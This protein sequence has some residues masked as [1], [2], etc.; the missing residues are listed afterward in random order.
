[1]RTFAGAG[2]S[3]L[4]R[5]GWQ[6]ERQR[7][8]PTETVPGTPPLVTTGVHLRAGR[9]QL[10]VAGSGGVAHRLAQHAVAPAALVDAV[11]AAVGV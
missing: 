8:R 4:N 3:I 7:R 11:L 6:L 5:F 1:M 9:P 2:R 10:A